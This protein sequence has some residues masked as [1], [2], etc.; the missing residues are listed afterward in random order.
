[1][2]PSFEGSFFILRIHQCLTKNQ[3][4][5]TTPRDL[6]TKPTA[7][8]SIWGFPTVEYLAKQFHLST[9]LIHHPNN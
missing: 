3:L 8:N 5:D 6:N 1:M 9:L 4:L 2:L 7:F